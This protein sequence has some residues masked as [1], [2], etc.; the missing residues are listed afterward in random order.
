MD[1]SGSRRGRQNSPAL[2]DYGFRTSG[3]ELD[4]LRDYASGLE[5]ALNAVKAQ[6][7]EIHIERKDPASE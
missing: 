5:E 3:D 4:Y 2:S 1:R 6:I 7:A